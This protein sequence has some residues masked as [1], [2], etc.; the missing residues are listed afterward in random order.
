MS[1]TLKYDL[2][3]IGGGPAGYAA[4]IRAGQLEKSCLRRKRAS[5]RYLFELGLYSSKHSQKVLFIKI[6]HSED[7]GIFGFSG[8]ILKNHWFS[9]GH[10][11]MKIGFLFKKIKSIFYWNWT[12]YG[13]RMVA[14]DGKILE[15]TID[16]KILIATGWE[17]RTCLI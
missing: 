16:D 11:N 7:F 8:L 12:N 17:A 4:A 1:N 13:S 5:G 9:Y 15:Y 14:K 2:V 6:N 3:V 10:D